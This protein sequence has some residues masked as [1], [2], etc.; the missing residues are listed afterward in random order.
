[1]WQEFLNATNR[2][3]VQFFQCNLQPLKRIDA[4]CLASTEQTIEH[5]GTLG[6]ELPG[7]RASGSENH[8]R[9]A[10]L[11][12]TKKPLKYAVIPWRHI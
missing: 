12:Q 6:C 8:Q 11:H 9:T 1:M 5:G 7:L 4:I 3:S 10:P 2:K